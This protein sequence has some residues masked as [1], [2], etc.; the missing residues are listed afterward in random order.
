M[1]VNVQKWAVPNLFFRFYANK[2][3][4][5]IQSLS[6]DC[7]TSLT[8]AKPRAS[9][10]FRSFLFAFHVSIWRAGT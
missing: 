10:L 6:V 1:F 9:A 2:I 8:S 7:A 3:H 5:P 4:F